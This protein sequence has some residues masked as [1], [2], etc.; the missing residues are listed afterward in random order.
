MCREGISTDRHQASVVRAPTY[1]QRC[2][3]RGCQDEFAV[4]GISI[5]TVCGLSVL[6]GIVFCIL[7]C[8]CKMKRIDAIDLSTWQKF[9]N[10]ILWIENPPSD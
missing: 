1:M 9:T 2:T 10:R 8:T 4:K 7:R 6:C 3:K 5:C